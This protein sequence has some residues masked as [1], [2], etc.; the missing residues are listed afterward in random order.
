M[1][2]FFNNVCIGPIL[3]NTVSNMANLQAGINPQQ[4]GSTA[5]QGAGQG[6]VGGGVQGIGS[7]LGQIGPSSE[8]QT[9][10]SPLVGI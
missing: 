2:I 8:I 4:Q 10:G 5:F 6:A 9:P 3:V 7:S 1:A